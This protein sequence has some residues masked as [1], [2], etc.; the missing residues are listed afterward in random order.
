[1]TLPFSFSRLRFFSD[2]A[3]PRGKADHLIVPGG[4]FLNG[5]IAVSTADDHK[6]TPQLI[7][8]LPADGLAQF[9]VQAEDEHIA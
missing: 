3:A 9:I 1:M 4:N 5:R 7:G 8:N 2:F 6:L